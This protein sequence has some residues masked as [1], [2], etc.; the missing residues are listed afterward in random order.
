MKIVKRLMKNN[1]CLRGREES[2]QILNKLNQ[3]LKEWIHKLIQ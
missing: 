2:K 3:N 1:L